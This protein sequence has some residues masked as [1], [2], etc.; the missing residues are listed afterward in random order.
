MSG[1][2]IV[3]T[4]ELKVGKYV[5]IDGEPSRIT[6]LT[7]SKPGKHGE[8]KIRLEGVGLFDNRKRSLL[9]PAG[10]KVDVPIVDKRTAQVLTIVGDN[11]QLMD[12]DT[13]ETFELPRPEEKDISSALQESAEVLYMDIMGRRKILQVK[14]A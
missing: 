9:K 5:F 3:E 7:K 4:S 1:K 10:H 8:A 12:M 6:S 2:K 14:S 11:I 13:Y